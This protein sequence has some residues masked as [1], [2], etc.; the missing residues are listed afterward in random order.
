MELRQIAPQLLGPGDVVL[1]VGAHRGVTA[2]LFRDCVGPTGLV[3]A[4]EPHP[5]HHAELARVRGVQSHRVALSDR[6]GVTRLYWGST[7]R[8]EQASSIC[9]EQATRDRLGGDIR[10]TEVPTDTIDAFCA[11]A[12][13]LRP[14]LVKIDVEGAEP[15]VF[16]GATE[17]LQRCRPT[18]VV[19][20]FIRGAQPGLP[21]HFEM[22][23]QLGYELL[24]LDVLEWRGGPAATASLA[25]CCASFTDAD[26]RDAMPV[27]GNILALPASR[28]GGALR[29][30]PFADAARDFRTIRPSLWSRLVDFGDRY[31]PAVSRAARGVRDR[32]RGRARSG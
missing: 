18:F 2:A 20:F 15:L 26:L 10:A 27:G 4:F 5:L 29:V 12:Q 6:I 7:P 25:D 11:R 23:R 8:A 9:V 28:R 22:L 24:I 32:A 1:D 21:R 31:T 16:A 30:V 19:E 13:G 3:H 17:M 14:S